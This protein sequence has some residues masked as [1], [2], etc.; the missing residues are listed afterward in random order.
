VLD[1]TIDELRTIALGADDASGHFPA[2]Y[3]R[4]TDRIRSAVAEGRFDDGDAMTRF[5]RRFADLYLEPRAGRTEIPGCWRAAWDVAGDGRLLIVQHLLLGMNAH[6]NYDL[7]L[8]V[9]A[10]AA[11]QEDRRDPHDLSFL[12]PDFDA[13]ND[14][15]VETV[16]DVLRDLGRA[17]RWV[18]LVAASG[19]GRLFNFSLSTARSQAWW[20]AERLHRLDGPA[21]T[22]D[23][24]ELDRLVRVLAHL[25]A[26]PGRPASWFVPVARRLET[27]DPRAVTR[28]LLGHLG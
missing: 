19:G 1:A 24:A 12:R 15:L 14:I 28:Q 17:S 23:V 2:M 8:A 3:A 20:A 27:R 22:A 10:A 13:V 25:I 11:D 5:A 4:V 21:R 18:N 26:R 9:V 16:P 7:P 6:I